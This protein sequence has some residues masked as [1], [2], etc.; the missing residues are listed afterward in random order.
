MQIQIDLMPE[1]FDGRPLLIRIRLGDARV[2]MHACHS[3][4]KAEF[5][6]AIRRNG[7][8][9]GLHT[10]INHQFIVFGKGTADR[11]RRYRVG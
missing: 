10:R 3:H 2:F 6:V 7:I 4:R 1:A 11:R 9:A 5:T 8:R